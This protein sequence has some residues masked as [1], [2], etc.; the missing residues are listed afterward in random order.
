MIQT[1]TQPGSA[2]HLRP[3]GEEGAGHTVHVLG[4]DLDADVVE[5]HSVEAEAAS[6]RA[7]VTLAGVGR[8]GD[9]VVQVTAR[10]VVAGC[11]VHI[12]LGGSSG[13]VVRRQYPHC[14]HLYRALFD[15]HVTER[16]TTPRYLG[17]RTPQ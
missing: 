7:K 6:Q 1:H 15:D 8:D 12:A 4:V 10:Q 9:G 3:R 2:P 13:A 14:L 11:A 17:G 5:A 16:L